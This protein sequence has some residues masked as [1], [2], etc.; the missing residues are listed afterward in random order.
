[1]KLFY[2][3]SIIIRPTKQYQWDLNRKQH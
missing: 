3:N 2:I 1:M